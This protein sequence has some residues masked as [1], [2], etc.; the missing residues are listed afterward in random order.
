LFSNFFFFEIRAVYEIIWKN[1]AADDNI[2]RR[3]RVECCVTK[4]KNTHSE[5]AIFLG[6]S[7]QHWLRERAS[8]LRY[9]Y[10]ICLVG[11]QDIR[12][13][14]AKFKDFYSCDASCFGAHGYINVYQVWLVRYQNSGVPFD[15]LMFYQAMRVIQNMTI[16][17]WIWGCLWVVK[18]PVKSYTL[19]QCLCYTTAL[20]GL[21]GGIWSV[22]FISISELLS[23]HKE[24]AKTDFYIFAA[25][26]NT[27]TSWEWGGV[28][29]VT[30][31]TKR[32]F[33]N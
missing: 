12:Q 7:R 9:T 2:I 8:V 21:Q 33:A 1:V 29:K 10:I 20:V 26:L 23:Y 25:E 27:D 18:C 4:A 24:N 17:D 14:N 13:C 11:I 28:S 5:Y 6:F 16:W 15:Q 31:L 22:H 32:S 30:P 3:M 19:K